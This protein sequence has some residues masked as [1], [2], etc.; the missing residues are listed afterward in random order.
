MTTSPD[1][2]LLASTIL[3][4]DELPKLALVTYD[5]AS[6]STTA[7]NSEHHQPDIVSGSSPPPPHTQRIFVIASNVSLG[8]EQS[9]ILVVKPRRKDPSTAVLLSVI[10]IL[11]E[12]KIE[13]EP[14]Q[15]GLLTA[16]A[17]TPRNHL[18]SATT[19]GL[20]SLPHTLPKIHTLLESVAP[21][22]FEGKN[23]V[24][25][26]NAALKLTLAHGGVS[27]C[28]VTSDVR[29]LQDFLSV[30]RDCLRAAQEHA[31]AS[32]TSHQWMKAYTDDL[33]HHHHPETPADGGAHKLD[34]PIFSRFSH[35]AF[36]PSPPTSTG[37]DLQRP[38][39]PTAADIRISVGTFN[40]NGQLPPEDIPSLIGFKKWVRAEQ[41]PDLL[42]L[43][44]QEVDTSGGAYLYHSPAREDA[45]TRTVTQALGRRGDK[46]RKIASKQLVGLMV[47]AFARVE[48]SLDEVATASVGVGLGGF[49]ANKGAV[50]V[51][52]KVGERTLCFVN[53]H[54]SAFEG[55]QAM[56]RR[57]WD[58]SE[59]YKRL[60]FR[61]EQP[62][63]EDFWETPGNA[64]AVEKVEEKEDAAEELGGGEEA[65]ENK[66][67]QGVNRFKTAQDVREEVAVEG[68]DANGTVADSVDAVSDEVNEPK[69]LSTTIDSPKPQTQVADEITDAS[70]HN[71]IS[72]WQPSQP[73]SPP[74]NS[75]TFT[76][77]TTSTSPPP[78]TEHPIMDHDI[79][80]HFGDLNFR[81]DLSHSEAHRLIRQ[82]DYTTL[83]RY[84]QLES[85]RTSGS[86]FDDFDEGPIGFAPTYKFDKGTDR[87]DTSEKQ[88]VPAWCDRVL[89]AVTREWEDEGGEVSATREGDE[90]KE[91]EEAR[92]ARRQG[93]VLQAYESVGELKFSDHRPVR[94]TLLVRVR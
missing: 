93:V 60:R 71:I 89:W 24:E 79:V 76:T 78:F 40:V 73:P 29:G 70:S 63:M 35:S 28:G 23:R 44:L 58:W 52:M 51:R 46:Y 94:A 16:S 2:Y 39:S 62:A 80:I 6:S 34:T 10:P 11:P 20:S 49:V 31:F 9:C 56:E 41:D 82:R 72:N 36:L 66:E 50:A 91:E 48:L 43:G 32:E 92:K 67:M 18:P 75:T 83:Y 38:A 13:I 33:P 8:V 22:V 37:P 55:L 30:L 17:A 81:L 1:P 4:P 12:L 19:L 15:Q 59:I 45:W 65:K 53:S 84:D 5:A 25:S 26:S 14:Q 47:L 74:P 64:A 85:L 57:C 68:H 86:L 3:T 54:L 42:V 90:E 88:R 7:A 21:D 69:R 87:Y 27:A 77:A 61:L